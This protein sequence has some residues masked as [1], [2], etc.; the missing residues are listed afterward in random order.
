MQRYAVAFSNCLAV[1]QRVALREPVALAV[2]VPILSGEPITVAPA[3]ASS[4]SN[5]NGATVN[6]AVLSTRGAQGDTLAM[7]ESVFQDSVERRRPGT[8]MRAY[9][10]R[11]LPHSSAIVVANRAPHEPRPEGGFTRGA[12]GVITAL[13]TIAEVTAAE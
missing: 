2:A 13:L 5:S 11:T 6:S 12:G 4:N 3:F 10:T 1:A 7:S 8:S 9:V